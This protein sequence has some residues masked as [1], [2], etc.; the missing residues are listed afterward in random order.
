MVPF[1]PADVAGEP[2][3]VAVDAYE[4]VKGKKPHEGR[5]PGALS[6]ESRH[7]PAGARRRSEAR[8]ALI[9]RLHRE[10]LWL[11]R[12]LP[13]GEDRRRIARVTALRCCRQTEAGG[14]SCQDPLEFTAETAQP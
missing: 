6:D 8:A 7:Y 1:T 2:L 10:R 9:E 5:A 4:S 11:I 12:E 3:T 13:M 14:K